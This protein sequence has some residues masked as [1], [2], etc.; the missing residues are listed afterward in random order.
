MPAVPYKIPI[1]G[2]NTLRT[3]VLD[4]LQMRGGRRG[5]LLHDDLYELCDGH[6]VLK[7]GIELLREG[8]LLFVIHLAWI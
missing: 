2:L 4:A 6:A 1:G 7:I 5:C 3:I 8:D